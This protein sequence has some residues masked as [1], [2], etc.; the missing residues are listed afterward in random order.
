MSVVLNDLVVAIHTRD[1]PL[2]IAV[3]LTPEALAYLWA[4]AHEMQRRSFNVLL[5]RE[6][7]SA[8]A[9]TLDELVEAAV[10][11]PG[12]VPPR[13]PILSYWED[14]GADEIARRMIRDGTGNTWRHILREVKDAF[15]NADEIEEY[16]EWDVDW[17]SAGVVLSLLRHGNVDKRTAK[18]ILDKANWEFLLDDIEDDR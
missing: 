10:G 5:G 8:A 1:L 17:T 12:P 3:Q 7:S 15:D 14:E 2:H 13:Y 4:K 9:P 18:A 6:R 16:D 11:P